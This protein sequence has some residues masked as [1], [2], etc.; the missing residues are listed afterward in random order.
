M[1]SLTIATGSPRFNSASVKR[2]SP[3]EPDAQHV[4]VVGG[5]DVEVSLRRMVA[6]GL[7]LE[8]NARL[9]DA[10]EGRVCRQRAVH[11]RCGI[12]PCEELPVEG[13]CADVIVLLAAQVESSKEHVLPMETWI[14]SLRVHEAADQQ[15]GADQEHHANR[16]LRRNQLTAE[17]GSGNALTEHAALLFQGA[18]EV[19]VRRLQCRHEPERHAGADREEQ[20]IE[21]DVQIGIRRDSQCARSRQGESVSRAERPARE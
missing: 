6:R 17:F 20:S 12:Q 10:F 3:G 13:G 9:H 11:V 15:P 19:G 5:D 7:A 18:G 16:D 4:K 8:R 2:A 14:D 21:E 1:A